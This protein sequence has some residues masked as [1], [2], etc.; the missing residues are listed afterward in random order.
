M[1]TCMVAPITTTTTT[2]TTLPPVEH[3]RSIDNASA[4]IFCSTAGCVGTAELFFNPYY[5]E[6]GGVCTLSLTVAQT[7]FDQNN[8]VTEVIEFIRVEG[9]D[10]AT[11][12]Q[13]G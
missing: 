6:H 1:V 10:V 4:P 3:V 9:E 7:D 13:P 2:T 5:A 11:N 12:V 8:G